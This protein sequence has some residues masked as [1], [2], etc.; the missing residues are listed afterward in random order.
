MEITTVGIDLAKYVFQVHA[1]SGTGEVLFR[2]ALRRAQVIPLFRK[3][4]S[5]RHK[6]SLGAR[7][8]R[9]GSH[10]AI[11]AAGLRQAVCEAGQ[12]RRR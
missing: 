3:V 12:D 6:P 8:D 5:L 11:D 9:F 4:A 7:A 1:I 2:R 10:S